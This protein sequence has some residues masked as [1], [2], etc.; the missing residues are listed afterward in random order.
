MIRW[1]PS[2]EA[3]GSITDDFVAGIIDGIQRVAQKTSTP[4]TGNRMTAA[5]FEARA[6]P[7]AAPQRSSRFSERWLR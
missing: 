5:N 3:Y 7:S 4:M 1:P 6:A 2:S